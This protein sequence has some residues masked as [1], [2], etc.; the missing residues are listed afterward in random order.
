MLIAFVPVI[1]QGYVDLFKKYPGELG[2][3][4]SDVIAKYTSI[5]RDLRTINPGAM[6]R[7]IDSMGLFS[8][9]R[10]LNA[11]DL[12][13]LAKG[14]TPIVMP[15]DEVAAKIIDEYGFKN[16]TLESI[17]LRWGFAIT[18]RESVIAPHRIISRGEFEKE[19]MTTAVE[20]AQ[21]S[22][23]WWRQ[24][25][26]VIVKDGKVIAHGH[27]HHLPTDYH[28]SLF[29]DPR[30][31]FDAGQRIDLSTAIHSEATVIASAAKSGLSLDGTCAFV[32]TFPC[33]NCARLLAEAGIKTVYYTKGY[34]LL[35]AEQVLNAF[36]VNIVLVDFT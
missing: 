14:S 18:T 6:K 35:D 16:V 7:I 23:D 17:F 12:A 13:D 1:H 28:L 4:G 10:V 31:N 15:D 2:I 5:S 11:F 29:G 27:N 33:P 32:T 34:S 24:V 36:N 3:L 21:K 9:V 8:R 26:T 25:G 19:M 30:T 20:E 22:A